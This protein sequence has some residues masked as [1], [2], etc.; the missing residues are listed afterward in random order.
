[1]STY[2]NK[3]QCHDPFPSNLIGKRLCETFPYLWNAIISTNETT[4][5]WQ[6]VAK[7]P[8]RPRIL[9]REWKDNSKLIGVRF[10]SQTSYAL[11]DIDRNGQFHPYQNPELLTLIRAAL[12]TIGICRTVLIRSSWS[13]GL[14]LYIPLPHAV[15]TFG[16]AQ[17]IKQCL[18]AQGLT[19]AQGQLEVFPNCKAYAVPGTYTEYNAHRLP[20]Q[21]ESGS[22]LLDDDYN[23][24][25]HDL[26]Q[27]FQ[28]WDIAAAGQDLS[29]L[30]NAIAIARTN[31]RNRR[32]RHTTIVEDW[33]QDL[34]AEIQEGWTDYG[35]TN[36]LLKTIAC[37]GVVF[38][39]LKGDAL[40]E[41]VEQTAVNLPGYEE[42]CQHRH[43]IR[44]RS[45]VWARSAENYY[46]ALGS[47]PK[48]SGNA[49]S[50]EGEKVVPL[51]VLRSEDAQRRI[52]AVVSRLEQEGQ[53]PSTA[54]A[55]AKL[56]AAE[57]I[58]TRTLYNHLELWHPIHY[59][60]GSCKTVQPETITAIF[61]ADSE[62]PPK[63]LEPSEEKRFYTEG[64]N[65]KGRMD[66]SPVLLAQL[67][68]GLES[69]GS[70]ARIH[71]VKP[72]EKLNEV[73]DS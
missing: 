8:I 16:L 26:G 63:S 45:T 5:K 67:V 19:I 44:M 66:N 51:N 37:H 33:L 49:H 39:G 57:G 53:F 35:Q 30:M 69:C 60:S 29:E 23:P 55:R 18:E 10:D 36:H 24:L 11:I 15:Q 68:F 52:K 41:Y 59:Q 58:S 73:N 22:C 72:L 17:A 61:E 70:E 48:R 56:I 9:W 27:F 54:T 47:N 42:W 62:D 31:N 25:S 14:H 3:S 65:M 32:K 7:Y 1:M 40:G 71:I 28:Q 50:D 21:P 38:E 46:W 6:T 4:P 12:E 20:L 43:E 2:S 13:E 64:K 34:R